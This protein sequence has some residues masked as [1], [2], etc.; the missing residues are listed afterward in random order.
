MFLVVTNNPNFHAKLKSLLFPGRND[1]HIIE[2]MYTDNRLVAPLYIQRS[3]KSVQ[4][5]FIKLCDM[6]HEAHNSCT[7]RSNTLYNLP[8]VLRRLCKNFVDLSHSS[9]VSFTLIANHDRYLFLYAHFYYHLLQP[10][11]YIAHQVKS[12]LHI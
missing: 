3:Q 2:I 6:S 1:R 7:S 8:L 9:K 11:S 12:R 5:H 4:T 10:F